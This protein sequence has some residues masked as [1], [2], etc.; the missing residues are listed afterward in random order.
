MSAELSCS[1][2]T[3]ANDLGAGTRVAF[4]TVVDFKAV[5]VAVYATTPRGRQFE[6]AASTDLD[7]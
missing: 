4:G 5:A 2:L 1:I 7:A 3:A 6:F